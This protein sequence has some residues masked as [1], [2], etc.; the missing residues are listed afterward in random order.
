MKLIDM[1]VENIELVGPLA[2]LVEHQHVIGDG[3]ANSR[4]EPK[5]G[6]GTRYEFC[7][8]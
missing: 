1:K 7:R 8:S 4:R 3:I 6:L 5:C 2:N